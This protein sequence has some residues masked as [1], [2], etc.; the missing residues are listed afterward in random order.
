[1][2]VPDSIQRLFSL[3]RKQD[4]ERYIHDLV[5][6]NTEF[7]ETVLECRRIGYQH[8]SQ[9]Y[10]YR[11]KDVRTK[12]ESLPEILRKKAKGD[13]FKDVVGILNELNNS[14]TLGHTHLFE[15]SDK[16][17]LFCFTNRDVS[18]EGTN[19]WEKGAHVH[20]I[21]F[22]T[23]NLAKETVWEC[24]GQKGNRP[25]GLHIRFIDDPGTP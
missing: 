8:R 5:L 23:T 7:A 12:F 15:S 19:H 9:H 6:T 2:P 17:H 1:M 16:W 18:E 24:L 10:E 25:T 13:S 14:R 3:T 4:I 21:N 22:L 20:F 11:P